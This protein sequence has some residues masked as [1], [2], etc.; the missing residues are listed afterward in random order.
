[1]N[2]IVLAAGKGTRMRSLNPEISKVGYEILG[3]P[4]VKYV[5]KAADGIIDG[6][7]IVVVGFGGEHTKKLVENEAEVVWQRQQLGTAHAI[8]QTADI[9]KNEEGAT[10]ILSGDTP[11][12]SKESLEKLIA[13]HFENKLDLTIL[14]AEP[15]SNFGY[16]R[17]IRNQNMEVV[18]IVEQKDGTLE[19]L[20]TKEVNAGVYL[21]D[22]KKLF[23]QL[24]F[25]N[26]NNASGELYL[27]DTIGLFFNKGYKVGAYILDDPDEM[28][29]TNDR[30][31]LAEATKILQIR[32]N[33]K[34]LLSGV[35]IED[36]TN[37]YIGPLV[38]IAQDSVI[39]PGTTILGATKIGVNNIIWQN[40]FINNTIIG[41]NNN[42]ITSH[43]EDSEI[44]DNNKI[45]PYAR[46]RNHVN[47][48]NNT[49]IGNFVELKN[50]IFKDGAKSAHLTYLGDAEIGENT[51]IGCGVITA[52]YDGVNKYRT[53]IGDNV[54]VGSNAT[55]IAPIVVKNDSFI[56]AGSTINKDIDENDFAIAR[57]R[58]ETKKGYAKV[59]KDN[60]KKV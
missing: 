46:L 24:E 13:Y 44:G 60:I 50:V 11:L 57:A 19:E 43:I 47:V 6:H 45:G 27:T 31:Q 5:L 55:L 20:K 10:L 39:K 7:K 32:I 35:T 26:T 9:L 58:Q 29:G 38:T 1:M 40:S 41:N 18:R 53:F 54:F 25:L 4:L 37:T 56:A 17:I 2:L 14:T 33:N 51:N 36:P 3:V 23:Q 52:N 15:A 8:M 59:I 48:N 28:L 49:R 34:H 30:L 21:F 12:L 16:G 42:I 22:N